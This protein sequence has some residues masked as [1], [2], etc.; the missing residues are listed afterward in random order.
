ME[1][2]RGGDLECRPVSQSV[3]PVDQIIVP[4]VNGS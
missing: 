3:D 1:S 4:A 2:A